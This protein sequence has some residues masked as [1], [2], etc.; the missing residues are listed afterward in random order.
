MVQVSMGD[1]GALL[2]MVKNCRK[3]VVEC[4][5]DERCKAALDALTACGLNDQVP[6]LLLAELLPRS[7]RHHRPGASMLRTEIVVNGVP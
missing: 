1:A 6:R 4:V 7:Q 5:Q 2:C 3:E